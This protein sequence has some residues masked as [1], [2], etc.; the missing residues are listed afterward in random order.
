MESFVWFC[1]ILISVW[2]WFPGP[3]SNRF[4]MTYWKRDQDG[5]KRKFNQSPEISQ[6][7]GCTLARKLGL[8]ETKQNRGVF[9]V[10][11]TYRQRAGIPRFMGPFQTKG[12]RAVNVNF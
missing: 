8:A 2:F 1:S 4:I 7:S 10:F 3:A 5:T 9:P 6:P 11:Y 12:D